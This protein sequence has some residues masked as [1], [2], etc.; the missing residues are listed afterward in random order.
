LAIGQ[1][2]GS[3]EAGQ[4]SRNATGDAVP[5]L[6]TAANVI[7]A[8]HASLP[9]AEVV[10]LGL[11]ALV[12]VAVQEIW[13]LVRHANTITHEAAH[14]AFG[15]LIGRKIERISLERNGD[16][17]TRLSTG[18]AAGTVLIG[19][20]GYLGPSLFGLGAAKLISMGQAV[21]VL[22]LGLLLLVCILFVLRNAFGFAS[23][24][25]N[26]L[27]LF[28]IVRYGSAGTQTATA[29]GTTWF[30][31]LAGVRQVIDHG[32]KAFDADVLAKIT[33]IGK[34]FWVWLWLAGT[35]YALA[36]GGSMLV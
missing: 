11:G 17:G 28:V 21:A 25:I 34:G 16:G 15:S 27:L 5:S 8:T 26:G 7:G 3:C 36:V 29:Y 14:A 33:H 1:S 10:L 35:V 23:V 19:F 20:V 6:D 12:A 13:E 31:L 32:V 4:Y 18:G 22:W 24:L 9:A 2:G 30:L